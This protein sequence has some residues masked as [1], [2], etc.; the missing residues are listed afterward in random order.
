M[1]TN[2]PMTESTI[3]FDRPEKI[4][5]GQDRKTAESKYKMLKKQKQ[6]SKPDKKSKTQN[7]KNVK[8]W[9]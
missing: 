7:L 6:E 4:K 1:G 8:K 5:H 9:L 3:K 2:D